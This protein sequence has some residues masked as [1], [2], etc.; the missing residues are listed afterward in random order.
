MV[1]FNKKI[2]AKEALEIGLVKRIY[3]LPG[4]TGSGLLGRIKFC[5]KI[6]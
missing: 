3:R 2:G 4:K 5:A 1:L 6:L